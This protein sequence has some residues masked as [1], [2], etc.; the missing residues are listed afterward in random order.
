MSY[1]NIKEKFEQYGPVKKLKTKVDKKTGKFI[2]TAVI[3][4][5]DSQTAK[6]VVAKEK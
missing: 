6:N 4:F 5:E 2:G 3:Y 1:Q